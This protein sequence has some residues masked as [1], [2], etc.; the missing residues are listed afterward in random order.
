MEQI[1]LSE[2]AQAIRFLNSTHADTIA[3]GRDALDEINVRLPRG[4]GLDARV[5]VDEQKSSP[6]KII[7]YLE[8]HHLNEGGYYDGWTRH[9]VT[10]IP[11]F[12]NGYEMKVSGP[13]RNEIKTYLY[14]LF[15]N[16]FES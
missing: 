6:S 4:S 15:N 5:E 7:I 16:V 11:C 9:K 14:D 1:K 2:I 13:N 12:I 8:Y 3:R 10:V